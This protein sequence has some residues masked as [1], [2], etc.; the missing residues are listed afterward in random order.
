MRVKLRSCVRTPQGA[1]LA[2]YIEPFFSQ[3]AAMGLNPTEMIIFPLQIVQL[4]NVFHHYITLVQCRL[5]Y[6]LHV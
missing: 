1:L 5:K 4:H 6:Y 3:L 2:Q